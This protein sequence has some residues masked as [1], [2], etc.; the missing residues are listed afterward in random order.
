MDNYNN[1]DKN[2]EYLISEVGG[3]CLNNIVS[4]YS[5]NVTNSYTVALLHSRGVKRVTLSL[6]LNDKEIEDLITSY[7]KRYN[8]NP[9]LELIVKT[10]MEVMTL[11]LNFK[12][13]YNNPKYLIDR[14]NNKYYLVYKD[15]LM[16]IYDYKKFILN[17]YLKYFKLGINYLR[18]EDFKSN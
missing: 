15:N 17:D 6:E 7:K 1:L 9:N 12:D 16:Y 11:K 3:L 14:F 8:K 5:L 18:E 4:D 2:K 13:I 10:N